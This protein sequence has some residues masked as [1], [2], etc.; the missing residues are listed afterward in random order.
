MKLFSYQNRNKTKR[1]RILGISLFK[2]YTKAGFRIKKYFGSI[3]KTKSDRYLKK[4]YIL[5]I[6]IYKKYDTFAKLN[7]I[8]DL[9]VKN[10]LPDL[11]NGHT[12]SVRR[13]DDVFYNMQVL[14]QVSNMHRIFSQY[15]RAFEGK[16]VV[17]YGAGPSLKDYI[18]IPNAIQ[19]GVNGAINLDNINLDYLFVHDHMLANKEMNDRLD[20][21]KGNNCKKFYAILP[22]R[23]VRRIKDRILIDRIPQ[24][25]IY[26]A[27]AT[28]FLLEDVFGN[29]WGVNIDCEPFGDFGG[30]VFSALQFILY[31]HPKRIF[32]VGQDCNKGYFYKSKDLTMKKGCI[33]GDNSGKIWG[34][35]QFK[36][37]ANQMYPDVEIISINPVGLKGLF[38]DIYAKNN[39]YY[40]T[41][42]REYEIEEKRLTL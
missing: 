40:T 3:I 1:L 25:H 6:Q 38:K 15:K 39:R 10:I 36:N 12:Q 7:T 23:Q 14:S 21:Y 34:Y 22:H 18:H 11:E 20:K 13:I 16:D 4:Y 41:D 35:R 31:A 33:A 17:L 8:E 26:Q 42:N 9:I 19:V 28:P 37:F 29:K 32:L 30:A 5:G 24:Y 27:D 2:E